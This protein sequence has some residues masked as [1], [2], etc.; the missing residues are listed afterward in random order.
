MGIEELEEAGT[1]DF[2]EVLQS[3]EIAIM[4]QGRKIVAL[5]DELRMLKRAFS[6]H[7]NNVSTAHKL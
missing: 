4:E 2:G 1:P 3:H 7:F 6:Y 5:E